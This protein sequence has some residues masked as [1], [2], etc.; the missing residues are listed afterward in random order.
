MTRTHSRAG[1]TA[2]AHVR[3]ALRIG[4]FVSL[5]TSML[6][7]YR[8]HDRLTPEAA[9]YALRERYMKRWCTM[10]LT[11]FGVEVTHVGAPPPMRSPPGPERGTGRLLVSNH[12][13]TI[14]ILLLLRE[15]GGHIVS[16]DDLA[17]WPLI[18][19]AA[20]SVGTVFVDR[21]SATS[22]VHAI[23]EMARLMESGRLVSVFPEGTT[24]SGDDVHPFHKGAFV[25]AKMADVEILPVGIAYEGG[26]NAAFLDESFAQHFARL[27][28]APK[29]RVALAIGEPMRIEA[30]AERTAR[31]ARD[32]VQD[33]V[34][35]ARLTITPPST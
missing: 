14:D 23:R 31:A 13:S 4:A 20:R 15:F 22:G 35:R 33:L 9:R 6:G 30:N 25:A 29:T 1:D 19:A 5:T 11:L 21:S 2:L 12:R 18:G 16:R 8:T 32:R 3:S 28:G 34:A 7:V 24:F 27:T 26:S 17:D 10:L